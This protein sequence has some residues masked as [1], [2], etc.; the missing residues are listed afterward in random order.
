M[1]TRKEAENIGFVPKDSIKIAHGNFFPKYFE[2]KR[3]DNIYSGNNYEDLYGQ[4][5]EEKLKD[6]HTNNPYSELNI[7]LNKVDL[8]YHFQVE[9]H[10]NLLRFFLENAKPGAILGIN[11]TMLREKYSVPRNLKKIIVDP[12]LKL[13]FY[14]K[15]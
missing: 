7:C 6:C 5:L 13:V 8:F 3:V 9:R 11:R 12:N 4:F 15:K 2:I 14:K 10:E 1:L